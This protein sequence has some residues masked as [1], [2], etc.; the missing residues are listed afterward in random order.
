MLLLSQGCCF[1]QSLLFSYFLQEDSVKFL[2][3]FISVPCQ[4]SGRCGILSGRPAVQSS[5]RPDDVSYRPD[6]YQTK[7]S[8][9]RTTWIPVRTFLCVE[10][11]QTAPACICPDVSAAYPDDFQCSTKVQI[12]FPKSNMGRLLQSSRRRGFPSGRA[13][14]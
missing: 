8:S 7:A 11:L 5:S 12:F 10:K 1:I 14:P 13:T 6:A 9:V 4:L 3:K 2:R